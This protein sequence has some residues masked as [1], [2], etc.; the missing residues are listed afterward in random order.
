[1][2]AQDLD[3]VRSLAEVDARVA[4][5]FDQCFRRSEG[6]IST[7]I[8]ISWRATA[9][10]AEI[11][12]IRGFGEGRCGAAR[13]SG[14]L[15][16]TISDQSDAADQSVAGGQVARTD[17]RPDGSRQYYGPAGACGTSAGTG[18]GIDPQDESRE[19]PE[20]WQIG[21]GRKRF[22]RR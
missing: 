7:G 13:V 8:R 11:D 14:D 2:S 16:R 21:G 22:F 17:R 20:G 10:Q 5:I 18:G 15:R 6:V 19:E 9:S 4:Q 12:E 3:K 1:M